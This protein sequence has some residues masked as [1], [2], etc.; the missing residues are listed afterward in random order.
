MGIH[1][2]V[3]AVEDSGIIDYRDSLRD[4][5][6]FNDQT[7]VYVGSP[8]NKYFQ[9]YEF[10]PLLAKTGD[11]MQAFAK[12]LFDEVHPMWL[13]R[14]LPNNVLAYAGITYQF[15]GPNHNITN[16]AASGAQALIE[17]WHAIKSGQAERAVVV[18]YDMGVEP[19]SQFYY[20]KLGVLS[21]QHLKPFDVSH[22][23]TIMGEGAAAI[24]LESEQSIQARNGRAYGEFV[25]GKITTEGA[26]IFAIE[27]D[28]QSLSQLIE[29]TLSEH[30]LCVDDLGMIVA[31]GNGNQRSD[32]TEAMALAQVCGNSTPPVT[33]FKWATG[34]TICAAGILDTVL[35]TKSLYEKTVPG[36]A[37][38]E[39]AAASCAH[40]N[41][42]SDSSTLG[43][44]NKALVINR[45][46]GG[47]NVCMVVAGC[48]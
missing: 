42:S 39:Q 10:L 36:I 14:I 37:S 19:Q 32:E 1:A 17:A 11:D 7:G 35:A 9:Q 15:K 34:H 6:D 8:G 46:F 43:K 23:G 4:V 22:D 47:M 24:V 33:G 30:Q 21:H 38:F 44:K 40:L 18:G 5:T 48:E 2:A 29:H 31:H 16:H 41:V 20:D 13:L 3:K 28:G 25:G 26:G 45:G 27:K 12:Q